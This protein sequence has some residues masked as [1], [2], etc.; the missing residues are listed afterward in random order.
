MTEANKGVAYGV[1]AYLLWGA[2]ASYLGLLTHIP[3]IEIAA[4]RALWSLP[5][6]MLMLLLGTGA[7]AETS[8]VLRNPRVL[9]ILLVS[10]LLIATNWS[11]YIWSIEQHRTLESA[12]GYYIN[13]L[14]NVL[15]GYL[16]LKERFTR[17]QQVALGLASLAVGLQTLA[18]GVF[19]WVG[20]TLAASFCAYGFIRKQVPVSAAP[21][22]FVEV[23]VLSVPAAFYIG[24]GLADASGHFLVNL[25]DSA[26]LFGLGAFTAAPLL[27]YA[28]CVRRLRYSTVGV[29]QYISPSLVFLT[30]VFLF[31][32]PMSLFR[33]SSFGL[34]WV[35]LAIYTYSALKEDKARRMAG[36]DR[37]TSSGAQA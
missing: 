3:A 9:G 26:L 36:P 2:M 8:R 30:A 1:G 17:A 10:S 23:L 18:A 20:L 15:V 34:L 29:L 35:A 13:P 6:A 14:L 37:L 31:G 28:A 4:H 21:G 33:L 22:F 19:P 24:S 16:F 12:L 7:L 25:R 27:L 11:L 32:E 5:I